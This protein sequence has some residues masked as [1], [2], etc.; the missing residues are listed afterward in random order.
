MGRLRS[1]LVFSRRADDASLVVDRWVTAFNSNDV[2]AL[3]R[4][5]RNQLQE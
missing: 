2:D 5:G 4:R 1:V 3:G